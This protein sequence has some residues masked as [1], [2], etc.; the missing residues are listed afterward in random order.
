VQ[1]PSRVYHFKGQR[2]FG[3]TKIGKFQ[4]EHDAVREGCKADAQ[5]ALGSPAPLAL[6]LQIG[7]AHKPEN[8]SAAGR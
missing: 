1:A 3:F 7:R 6:R 5:W 4:C 8:W 2:Y